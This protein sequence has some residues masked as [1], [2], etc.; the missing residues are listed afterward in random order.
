MRHILVERARA[1]NADFRS[2]KWIPISLSK[3][4]RINSKP[5]VDVLALDEAL[6][7]LAAIKPRHAQIVEMRFFGGLTVEETAEVLGISRATVE[8][9]WSFARAWLKRELSEQQ[10][11]RNSSAS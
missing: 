9:E 5:D 10:R 4:D 8:R 2:G 3:A 7:K 6:N 1:R 11:E